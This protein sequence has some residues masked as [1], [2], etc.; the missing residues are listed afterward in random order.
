MSPLVTP[1]ILLFCLRT[2]A[3]AIVDFLRNHTVDVIGVGDV[4]AFAQLD[5]RKHGSPKVHT[6]PPF[7]KDNTSFVF[8][9]VLNVIVLYSGFRKTSRTLHPSSKPNMEKWNCHSCT[10]HLSTLSFNLLQSA[11]PSSTTCNYRSVEQTGSNV[12]SP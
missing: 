10:S 4:C 7:S 2:R 9:V 12:H 8:P 5:V 1:F 3:L 11:K 6:S